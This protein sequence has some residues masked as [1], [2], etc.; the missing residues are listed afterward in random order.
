MRNML[1]ISK[2]EILRLKSHF[3]GKSRFL[4]VAILLVAAV[5]SYAAYQHGL[6][7][8]KD[9]YD[10]G[11]S[12]SGPLIADE[13]FSV[14]IFDQATG[15]E[16]LA[17]GSV[18]VYA[19]GHQI[20]HRSDA[21]SESAF[22]ALQK[23][24]EKQDLVR[25]SEEYPIDRAFP[26][27]IKVYHVKTEDEEE[28]ETDTKGAFEDL[29]DWDRLTEP[30]SPEAPAEPEPGSVPETPVSPMPDT[31]PTDEPPSRDHD[32]T[33][34]DSQDSS[35]ESPAQERPSDQSVRDQLDDL[36]N[37]GLPAF[38]AEFVSDE[39]I[40]I[41]SLHQPP[42]PL[43]QV[44][45]SFLY[46]LPL[47]FMGIFFTS[48]LVEERMNR[49]VLVLL[50][51]PITP[52]EI[53]VGKMLPYL[54][55]AVV[56][57]TAITL[58]L[59]GNVPLALAIFIPVMLFLFSVYILVALLCRTFKDQTFMSLAAVWIIVAYLIAPAMFVGV[60][61]L[62]YLSP[63]TLAVEM[64]RG[65]TFGIA[66]YLLATLPMYLTFCLALFVG[67]RLL[68]EE[69]LST[70]KPVQQKLEEAI[71]L[72]LDRKHLG[73]SVFCF[74][75]FVIPVVFMIQFASIVLASN[76]PMA[77]ALAVIFTL[78]VITEEVAKSI[79][80]YVLLQNKVIESTR[81][82]LKLSL[83]SALGFFVGEKL[84]LFVALRVVSESMFTDAV[85]GSPFL[86]L[87]LILH[88]VATAIVGLLTMKLGVRY[89][90]LALLM[91]TIV[92]IGY[93]LSVIAGEL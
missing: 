78:A 13:R 80:L 58:V 10:V 79:A 38:K 36:E 1:I 69:Y 28:E 54:A 59:G 25:I 34:T 82:V 41:P 88:C 83:L 24:L 4:V 66:E 89:Y 50:S 40:V 6:N 12:P 30:S 84:L 51:T 72:V 92:H 48:S 21:R 9:L 14:A 85:F 20:A 15:L 93:N 70:F 43:A 60:S 55:Y 5:L 7:L 52:F 76:L 53:L 63:L 87:P 62:S 91:G 19:F 23:Y 22:G 57:I 47:F 44:S 29:L 18:D 74:S 2:R 67:S 46:V 16:K 8:S 32:S 77:A 11:V 33:S 35:A 3:A 86:I 64:Y 26:L 71:Y 61:N 65:E 49:K 37:G 31:H 27:R 45:L 90:V 68:N 73:F 42:M 17:D 81:S 56:T 39:E 75:L